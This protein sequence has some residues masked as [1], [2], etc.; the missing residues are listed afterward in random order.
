MSE[1]QLQLNAQRLLQEFDD[2]ADNPDVDPMKIG[3]DAIAALDEVVSHW[4]NMPYMKPDSPRAGVGEDDV[5]RQYAARQIEWA[6]YERNR[7]A[8]LLPSE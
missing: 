5:M 7:V 8:S 1:D 4:S 6:T 3:R 2:A